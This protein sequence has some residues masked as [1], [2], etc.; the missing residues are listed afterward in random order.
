MLTTTVRIEFKIGRIDR[1]K[2][3]RFKQQ[4]IRKKKNEQ[5]VTKTYK[6][7]HLGKPFLEIFRKQA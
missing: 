6:K 7:K 5:K 2:R 1:Y 3:I 4:L